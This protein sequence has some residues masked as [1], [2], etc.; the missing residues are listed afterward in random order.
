M[1][2]KN[3]FHSIIN[4]KYNTHTADL[5][6]E[7]KLLKEV[8]KDFT[9]GHPNIVRLYESLKSETTGNIY[10]IMEY[11]EGD[12]EDFTK[13]HGLLSIEVTRRF[14]RHIKN[15][16]QFLRIKNIIHRDLKPKNLLVTSMN[17]N[18]ATIKLADFGLARTLLPQDLAATQCGSPLYMAPELLSGAKYGENVDLWSVGAI[19]NEMVTG[20]KL[21]DVKT[22]AQLKKASKKNNPSVI[23]APSVPK[24]EL[25]RSLLE[26]LLQKDP[27]KRI[28]YDDFF[29]HPFMMPDLPSS[30]LMR[31][32]GN[33]GSSIGQQNG[34]MKTNCNTSSNNTE[35]IQNKQGERKKERE[36]DA[37]SNSFKKKD[38]DDN[39]ND[40]DDGTNEEASNELDDSWEMLSVGDFTGLAEEQ[41]AM[42]HT[43]ETTENK[44]NEKNENENNKKEQ[45]NDQ[46][47]EH[48]HEHEHEHENETIKQEK[49]VQISTSTS[50]SAP[51]AT[52]KMLE[53][54]ERSNNATSVESINSLTT[55]VEKIDTNVKVV[56]NVQVIE[57]ETK[58]NKA[59][60]IQ[61]S[62][63]TTSVSLPSTPRQPTFP[64]ISRSSIDQ[65]NSIVLF[66]LIEGVG[67]HSVYMAFHNGQHS[68]HYLDMDCVAALRRT[69]ER[70]KQKKLP[71]YFIG[72]V[73]ACETRAA[74][75]TQNPYQLLE[76]TTF[77]ILTA[78]Q[79]ETKSI[80]PEVEL[81]TTSGTQQEPTE[82]TDDLSFLSFQKD[83]VVLG[84]PA[85]TGNKD[86]G[87]RYIAF[88][89]IRS[90]AASTSTST[91]TGSGSDNL[92]IL[93][94]I[95]DDSVAAFQRK[96]QQIDT[97]D[98]LNYLVG[99]IIMLEN[100][101][102]KEKEQKI[103][104]LTIIPL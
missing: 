9:N 41:M 67:E 53:N 94:L 3:C 84:L 91:N 7:E 77:T 81:T 93:Y 14:A 30:P 103:C 27:T 35:I 45:E 8:S 88:N 59:P 75:P 28:T 63:T 23:L 34:E 60:P 42:N 32:Q 72:T 78:K 24:K 1:V 73:I 99:R 11:C 64:K 50:P 38:Q 49:N 17:L 12:L 48:E 90:V 95:S 33:V 22:L 52:S 20:R 76:G 66:F 47:N 85:A 68:H 46:E 79:I 86:M 98:R 44:K 80:V 10:L 54:P 31:T 29:K 37:S 69:Q 101:E 2:I 13:R 96:Q 61:S 26:G 82:L 62:S 100:V 21:Y 43:T 55:S 71:R 56:E 4:N 58:M 40:K 102:V 25:L 74:S 39:N 15:A 65:V 51:C 89:E 57:G 87:V 83:D 104:M 6:L 16:L 97:K 18:T 70:T 92:D 5:A 19:I 36:K